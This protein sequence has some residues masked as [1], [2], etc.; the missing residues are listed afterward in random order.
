MV[1]LSFGCGIDGD[2]LREGEEAEDMSC[3]IEFIDV[4]VPGVV[5]VVVVVVAFIELPSLESGDV[6]GDGDV[7]DSS[8]KSP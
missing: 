5:V 6:E 2:D 3:S 7:E 4:E 8:V 1:L